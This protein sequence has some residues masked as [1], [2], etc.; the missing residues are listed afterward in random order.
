VRIHLAQFGDDHLDSTVRAFEELAQ[1]DTRGVHHLTD[2]PDQADIVLFTQCHLLA[3]DWRLERIR[4]HQL[5]R[6]FR[7]KTMVYDER[8]RPWAA[9][10]GVYVSMPS[11]YF[12]RDVQRA[13]GYYLTPDVP[14]PAREPDVLFS[15]VASNS[16][17]CRTPLFSLRHPAAVVEEIHHFA[18]FDPSSPDFEQRRAR[19][20][21]ILARSRF[22]LC[23]RG[24]GTSS[25]RMY[26]AMAAGKVPVVVADDWVAPEGPD[27]D[28]FSIR[29]PEHRVDGLIELLEER[30]A[31]SG[32]MGAAAQTAWEEFF[33]P[34]VSFDRIATKCEE[35]LRA[36]ATTG[37]PTKGIRDRAYA[38]VGLDTM[39]WRARG[40]AVRALRPV[41]R[42]VRRASA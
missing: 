35:L 32:Q 25:I 27:W 23:P 11:Q 42:R 41:I 36:G 33:G 16:A 20:R 9:F 3:P 14:P 7:E 2:S 31:E 37:F 19:F 30:D 39:R 22:V 40:T 34:A 6:V 38:H 4:S 5:A 15:L 1:Q 12:G 26:E 28:A 13:W 8:D 29:W 24:R 10:P 18:F 17:S 21:S